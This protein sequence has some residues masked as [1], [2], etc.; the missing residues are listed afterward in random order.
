MHLVIT[1]AMNAILGMTFA[2]L[3]SA[4]L[5]TLGAAAFWGIGAYTSVLL[6]MK[7][8]LSFWLALPLSAMVSGGA[9]LMLG[10][11][12][13]RSPRLAFLILTLLINCVLVEGLG[14]I[15]ALGGWAGIMCVPK[16]NPIPVPFHTPIEFVDKVPYYYLILFLLLLTVVTFYA[17]YTS[18]IG[19]VWRAIKLNPSL[20]QSLG[21]YPYKYQLLAFVIASTFAGLAGSFYAHYFQMVTPETFS[22]LKSIH[23]QIY[24]ILGG[25]NFYVMGPVI[26][27][28]IFT[29]VP[30]YL[31]I[32]KEVEPVITGAVLIL[33]VLFL[34]NGLAG[35]AG[36][37]RRLASIFAH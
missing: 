10:T 33:L 1:I 18:R 29:L 21:I 16:P 17:F 26:G 14:G 27:S 25:L 4:G 3:Y 35:I 23:I 15:E 37:F 34:P 2:L 36:R 31:R 20:A 22:V 24:A 9:A 32:A 7:L 28:I 13:V 5:I 19:R 8:G 12:I 11:I 6:V 30:E